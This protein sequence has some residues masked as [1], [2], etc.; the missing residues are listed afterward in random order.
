VNIEPT[1]GVDVADSYLFQKNI[2]KEW[3]ETG[4]QELLNRIK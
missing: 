3:E 2:L 4:K 1:E